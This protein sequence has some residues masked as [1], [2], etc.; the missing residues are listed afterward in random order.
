MPSKDR[1]SPCIVPRDRGG[2]DSTLTGQLRLRT[3]LFSRNQSER[4]GGKPHGRERRCWAQGHLIY[5][6]SPHPQW[7]GPCL[8]YPASFA[9]F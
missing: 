5:R 3:L 6:G 4:A 7:T 1:G 8:R 9:S 2:S